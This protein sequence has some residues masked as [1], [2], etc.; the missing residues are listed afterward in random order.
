MSFIISSDSLLLLIL[1]IQLCVNG[2]MTG[3]IWFV[4]SVHY[5]LFA[6]VD[7][8]HHLIYHQL[9]VLKTTWV[10]G[11]PMLIELGC[12]V[13]LWVNLMNSNQLSLYS[14]VIFQNLVWATS[15]CLAIVWLST[16]CLQVPDH[17]QLSQSFD[18]AIHHHLV[19]TNWIRTIGWS[20]KLMLCGWMLILFVKSSQIV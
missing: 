15:L 12:T 10:V 16:A 1:V 19:K 4:Q 7:S 17:T 14:N 11:P 18:S 6:Q 2:F 13:L 8:E 5:P 9:H 3:L 20:L